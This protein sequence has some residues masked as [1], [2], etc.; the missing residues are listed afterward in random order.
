MKK[1]NNLD[2]HIPFMCMGFL[3]CSVI[4]NPGSE[5][6]KESGLHMTRRFVVILIIHF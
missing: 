3:C 1:K 4:F 6:G 2:L 5:A